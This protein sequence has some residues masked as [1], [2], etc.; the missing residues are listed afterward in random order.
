MRKKEKKSKL[1]IAEDT[2]QKSNNKD[3][4]TILSAAMD[5]VGLICI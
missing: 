3:F 2:D 5:R 1:E 4:M